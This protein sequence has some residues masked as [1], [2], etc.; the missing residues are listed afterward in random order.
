MKSIVDFIF[1]VLAA[2]LGKIEGLLAINSPPPPPDFSTK[3]KIALLLSVFACAPSVLAN[4]IPLATLQVKNIQ[5]RAEWNVVGGS[6]NH[7]SVEGGTLM[8]KPGAMADDTIIATVEVRDK[9][10][11][12]NPSYEDLKVTVMIT[13]VIISEY[14]NVHAPLRSAVTVEYGVV[15][16]EGRAVTVASALVSNNQHQQIFSLDNLELANALNESY[17][18]KVI[19]DDSK[20]FIIDDS[21]EKGDTYE[22]YANITS[23]IDSVQKNSPHEVI[24][25]NDCPPIY[26]VIAWKEIALRISESDID[27]VRKYM[28]INGT[29]HTVTGTIPYGTSNIKTGVESR[30]VSASG[31]TLFGGSLADGD[32]PIKFADHFLCEGYQ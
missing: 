27:K 17:T 30:I 32:H 15:A 3:C 31:L 1:S 2:F 6:A 28:V 29:T 8:L 16:V 5:V 12:L 25:L 26:E 21:E 14:L 19:I 22:Y 13:A 9:F 7:F 4:D 11:T 18:P 24:V 10:S 20:A 23:V